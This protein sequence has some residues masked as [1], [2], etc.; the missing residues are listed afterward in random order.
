M[1]PNFALNLSHDGIDLFHRGKSGWTSVGTVALDDPDLGAALGVL[2]RTA[3]S[4]ESGGM[5]SKVVIP[6]SQILYTDIAAPQDGSTPEPATIRASLEGLTPYAVGDLAFDWQP[7]EPG[8]LRLAVVAK[9]TLAEA[10]AFAREHRFNPVAFVAA[11]DPGRFAGE[12]FFG[13]AASAADLLADTGPVEPDAEPLDLRALHSTALGELGDALSERVGPGA[14]PAA[15]PPGGGSQVVNLHGETAAETAGET[16]LSATVEAAGDEVPD[17]VSIDEAEAEMVPAFASRRAAGAAMRAERVPPVETR[18]AAR[19]EPAAPAPEADPPAER[20]TRSMPRLVAG[21]AM[22]AGEAPRLGSADRGSKRQR[23]AGDGAR[24][25]SP[26]ALAEAIAARRGAR[27][28]ARS[29][30]PPAARPTASPGGRRAP[31]VSLAR[32]EAAAAGPEAGETPLQFAAV[33]RPARGHRSPTGIVVLTLGLLALLAIFALWSTFWTD[34]KLPDTTASGQPAIDIPPPEAGPVLAEIPDETPPPDTVATEP[35]AADAAADAE[36]QPAAA[37]LP[38]VD[39]AAL[40]ADPGPAGRLATLPAGPGQESPGADL[41]T[42]PA[43]QRPPAAVETDD[44][45]VAAPQVADEVAA[46]DVSSED[47]PSIADEELADGQDPTLD[48]AAADGAAGSGLALADPV[49]DTPALPRDPVTELVPTD[50]GAA[51]RVRQQLAKDLTPDKAE[52][53]Y[54]ASGIWVLP[55]VP[56]AEPATDGVD[57]LYVAAIDEQ[58]PAEDAAA[59]PVPSARDRSILP[60][61]SPM[62]AGTHFDL[63][64]RGLVKATPEGA[65]NPDGI[66]IYLGAPPLVPAARPGSAA[67]EAAA[68]AAAQAAP[69]PAVPKVRPRPR[70]TDLQDNAEKAQ[71]GGRT[72]IQLATIQPRPRPEAVLALAAAALAPEPAVAEAAALAQLAPATENAVGAS[73]RP[74]DRPNSIDRLV[75]LALATPAPPAVKAA[76]PVRPAP[77]PDALDT[78]VPE[79]DGEPGLA[80][81]P[82][83]IPRVQASAGVAKT[84]TE[85]NVLNLSKINLIG[86]YGASSERRALVRLAN[87]K[88]VKVQVGDRIDGGKVAAI[89]ESELIYVKGGRQM[90]LAM[91]KT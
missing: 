2:R 27:S 55:P 39:A 50:K 32:P 6:N 65:V 5:T 68:E 12:P 90:R 83:V 70:P 89:G 59:L 38:P 3:V 10:E 71:L 40:P 7:T 19:P 51:E 20:P 46:Q 41:A 33:D 15:P 44:L 86:V 60:P 29:S 78:S 67:A 48:P 52:R 81:A 56:P 30:A 88:Y 45:A 8:R 63:D 69:V 72:R 85:A 13:T 57:G 37:P 53:R 80:A 84:A 9:E 79:A 35:Q 14:D 62:P 76:V 74:K 75:R 58:V 77:V 36:V 61:L 91:P 73:P 4:L 34:S 28:D 54:A 25:T 21:S 42:L 82:A 47:V 87:G 43:D 24:V 64:D 16:M 22:P 18:P 31:V 17:A 66:R 23:D 26:A 49:P 1:K 11:P